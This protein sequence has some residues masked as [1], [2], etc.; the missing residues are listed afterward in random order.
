MVNDRQDEAELETAPELLIPSSTLYRQLTGGIW[1]TLAGGGLSIASS[2]AYLVDMQAPGFTVAH[3]LAWTALVPLLVVLRTYQGLAH[4]VS[5][6]GL[7][8]SAQCVF[9]ALVLFEVMD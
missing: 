9:A 8:T 5:S 6:R 3:G 7:A 1:A 4:E 2:I